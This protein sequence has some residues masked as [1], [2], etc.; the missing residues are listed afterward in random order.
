[1]V[2]THVLNHNKIGAHEGKEIGYTKV[3]EGY[4]MYIQM[5]LK[6]SGIT[7]AMLGGVGY[8]FLDAYFLSF[9]TDFIKLLFKWRYN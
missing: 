5:Y 2:S 3:A 8:A 6:V 1:M 4:I 7:V 9:C